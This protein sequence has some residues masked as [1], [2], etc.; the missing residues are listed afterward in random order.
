MIKPILAPFRWAGSKAKITSGLFDEFIDADTYVEAFLGSGVVL[1]RLLQEGRYKRYI[2]NDINVSV[3]SF[4]TSLQQRPDEV[5]ER[6]KHLRDTYNNHTNKQGY[7]YEMRELFNSDKSDYGIFWLM[8]KAGFNGLYRENKKGGYN[9]PFG[10]KEKITLNVDQ[11]MTISELIQPVEFHCL[12]F[13]DF[14]ELIKHNDV[15]AYNDPPYCQSQQYT[16]DTFDN[17]RLANYL[18]DKPYPVS[19]S[20]IDSE[21]ANE[22]YRQYHKRVIGDVKRIIRISDI[23][24]V[25]EVVF[26]NYDEEDNENGS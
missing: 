19:I 24:T 14:Y 23:K 16:A 21:Q 9:V 7:Y 17:N 18:A 20:D 5:I 1:F 11:L 13:Q 3:I 2:V 26:C 6:L 25:T 8:M 4:Y 12:D 10:K 22:V 15:Y